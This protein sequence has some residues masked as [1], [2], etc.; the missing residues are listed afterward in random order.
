MS[1]PKVSLSITAADSN[2]KTVTTTVTYVNA[3]ASNAELVNFAQMLNALTDNTYGTTTKVT[4][5]V[6]DY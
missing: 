3:S 6:L 2:D 1:T 5:E 4:K